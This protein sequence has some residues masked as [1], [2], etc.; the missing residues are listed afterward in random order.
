M[1]CGAL[2][3]DLEPM[4]QPAASQRLWFRC[5]P[6][7]YCQ[8]GLDMR[9][10]QPQDRMPPLRAPTPTKMVVVPASVASVLVRCCS[11]RDRSTSSLLI[12]ADC[13]RRMHRVQGAADD[14]TALMIAA[15]TASTRAN[16]LLRQ[17]RPVLQAPAV[18]CSDSGGSTANGAAGGIAAALVLMPGGLLLPG[19]TRNAD[20]PTA[21]PN[22][23]AASADTDENGRVC[24]DGLGPYALL[25]KPQPEQRRPADTHHS[26]APHA[27]HAG[28]S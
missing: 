28:R 22:A 25:L 19:W 1:R 12:C 10:N 2:A 9:L 3:A 13:M 20:V 16:R 23:A 8:G 7:G 11:S 6:L 5:K 4:A 27:P 21:R 14:V 26:H 24:V 18:R 15:L 17:R